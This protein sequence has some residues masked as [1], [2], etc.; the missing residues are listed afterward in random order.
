MSNSPEPKI[1]GKQTPATLP[2]KCQIVELNIGGDIFTTALSTLK[3]YPGSIL[4]EMFG[5]AKPRTDSLGRVFIDRPGTYFKY[6]L[7]YLR[8]GQVPLKDVEEVYKEATYY[9]IK[10]L[11]K[12]LEESPQIFGELVARKQFLARVPNYSENIE[13]MIRIARAEAVASRKSSVIFCVMKTLEDVARCS[14]AL[15]SLDTSKESVVQFGPWKAAPDNRDLLD[16][17]KMDMDSKGYKTSFQGFIP[18]KGFRFSSKNDF[19]Y[20]CLFHWW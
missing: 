14:D 15:S 7:E 17:I 6:I 5:Q 4:A 19:F 3:K 2:T 9:D 11:I 10:P 12:Q 8:S 20:K 1:L 16:C 13:L 18:D